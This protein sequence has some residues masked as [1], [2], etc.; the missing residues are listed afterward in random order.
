VILNKDNHMLYST[1][2][3]YYKIYKEWTIPKLEM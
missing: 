2:G 3:K 1:R